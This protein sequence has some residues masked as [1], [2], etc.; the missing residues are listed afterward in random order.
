MIQDLKALEKVQQRATKLVCGLH[1]LPYEERLRRLE[2]TS[3]EERIRRGDLIETFKILSH[4]T[5]TEEETYF[6]RHNDG[7][8]R[9]HNSKL[10]VHRANLPSKVRKA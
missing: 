9:G 2:L 7:T 3:V 5:G 10:K 6:A 4:Q 1:Q 8:T